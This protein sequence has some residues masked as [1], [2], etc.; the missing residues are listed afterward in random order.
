MTPLMALALF[1]VSVVVAVAATVVV[2][3]AVDVWGPSDDRS[4]SLR[5]VPE[6]RASGRWVR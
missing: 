4:E 5:F 1:W 6:H 3:A 2:M